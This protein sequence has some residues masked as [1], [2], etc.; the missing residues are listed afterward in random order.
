LAVGIA[1]LLS[2]LIVPYGNH[3]GRVAGRYPFWI[4]ASGSYGDVPLVTPLVLQTAFSAVAAGIIV[5][6]RWRRWMTKSLLAAVAIA[7]V[8]L[9][10]VPHVIENRQIVGSQ[11]WD[12]YA[13]HFV[14]IWTEH[15]IDYHVEW[16]PC[17]TGASRRWEFVRWDSFALQ[18][19][20]ACALAA[21]FVNVPWR[22]KTNR[23]SD[24]APR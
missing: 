3:H 22:R 8:S 16:L 11:Q 6:I 5:N 7:L 10:F 15:F 4:D 1:V 12:Y 13:Q 21:L 9:L 2:L 23:T 19:I 24:A 14:P 18:T 17:W 20:G